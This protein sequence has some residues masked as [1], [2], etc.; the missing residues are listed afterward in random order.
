MSTSIR[1][2]FLIVSISC[3]VIACN[4]KNSNANNNQLMAYEKSDT[5]IFNGCQKQIKAKEGSIIEI[6]LKAVPVIGYE[7]IMKDSSLLLK[8]HKTDVLKYLGL[9]QSNFQVLHFEAERIGKEAIQLEYKRVFEED[10][11]NKCIIN[12]EI[13]R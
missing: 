9:G 8:E 5:L 4:M 10:I 11:K 3:F 13:Y 7:W 1:N 6:Q 2:Y 12:F